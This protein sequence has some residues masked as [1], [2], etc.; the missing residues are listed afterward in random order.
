MLQK[1]NCKL[2]REPSPSELPIA[3][4]RGYGDVQSLGG[5]RFAQ[6]A[7]KAQFNRFGRALVERLQTGQALVNRQHSFIELPNTA[8]G[9][10][11]LELDLAAAALF[12]PDAA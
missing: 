3:F 12:A 8:V 11:K 4:Q 10:Q 2:A 5:I 1:S 7:E 9:F 6:A